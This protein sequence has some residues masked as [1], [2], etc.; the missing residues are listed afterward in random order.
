MS[1]SA[2]LTSR[3]SNALIDGDAEVA[4]AAA[5]EA[6]NGGADPLALI[7]DVMIP[8]LTVVGNQFQNGEVFLPEL[9]LAGDAAQQVSKHVE[10][11]IVAQGKT[12]EPKGVIVIGTVQGDI[13][14]IGKNIV[15]TMLKAHGFRVVDLGRNVAPS[16]FLTAAQE[17]NAGVVA[18]SSLMTTTRPMI[19]NTINLFVEVGE[20]GKHR[21]IVGGGCVTEDWASTIGADGY[22]ADAVGAVEL[23]KQFSA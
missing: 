20:R 17:N 19:E 4:E 9:M 18:M 23:C 3:L 21:M 11:A 10:A 13:H 6:L 12:S 5:V 1:I 7:N 16:G 8:T 15:V 2:E 22:S 14:D